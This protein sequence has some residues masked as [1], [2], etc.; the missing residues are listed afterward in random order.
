M[1]K[2][3]EHADRELRAICSEIARTQKLER[4]P[5]DVAAIDALA[6]ALHQAARDVAH[7]CMTEDPGVLLRAAR[8]LGRTHAIPPMREDAAWFF[9]MLSCLVELAAPMG[10]ANAEAEACFRDIER[11]IAVA[12]S[13]QVT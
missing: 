5:V 3:D 1:L 11:G 10:G 6:A 7:F 12:R 8:Y 4:K 9:N 13:R 2:L